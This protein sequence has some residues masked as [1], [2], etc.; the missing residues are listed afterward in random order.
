MTSYESTTVCVNH[1]E[2]ILV[3]LLNKLGRKTLQRGPEGTPT[4]TDSSPDDRLSRDKSV[5]PVQKGGFHR[6]ASRC[7]GAAQFSLEETR[8]SSLL[9]DAEFAEK[10]RRNSGENL[11]VSSA[12]PAPPRC[13]SWLFAVESSALVFIRCSILRPGLLRRYLRDKNPG[14]R[15]FDERLIGDTHFVGFL[16]HYNH[17]APKDPVTLRSRS[18]VIQLLRL[19]LATRAWVVISRCNSGGI[20]T[21]KVPE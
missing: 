1:F 13:T 10:T 5:S 18:S 15:L 19:L 14:N 21:V 20:R 7:A 9:V 6:G 12:L 17:P 2:T 16:F 4:R 11:R 8:C 3:Y